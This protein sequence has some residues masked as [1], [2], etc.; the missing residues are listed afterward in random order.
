MLET[1][2]RGCEGVYYPREDSWMLARAVERYA[3]GATL[4]LCTGTGIQGITAARR[5]CRVTF[6]DVDKRAVNC[7]RENAMMNG[8]EG[9]FILSDLFAGVPERFNTIICNPPYLGLEGATQRKELALDA[10]ISGRNVIDRIIAE[11]R[12]HVLEEHVVLIVES[13]I[14]GYQDD[15]RALEAEIVE[16]EHYMFEDIVVLKFE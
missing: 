15:V 8:V 11:Y 3:F 16:K 1:K 2:I 14:N 12:S 10:G 9:R 5:G 7:A 13:S 6:A 4:D